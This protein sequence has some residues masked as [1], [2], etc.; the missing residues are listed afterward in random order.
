M[1]LKQIKNKIDS[2]K[3]T[4][5]VTKAMEAVSAVKMRKSQEKAL[6]GRSYAGAALSILKQL[7]KTNDPALDLYTKT[8]TEGKSLLIIVTSDKGLAGSVNSA[9]LK[10]AEQFLEGKSCDTICI[11][12]KAAEF[13]KREGKEVIREYLNVQDDVVMDDIGEISGMAMGRF[14]LGEYKEVFI[15]YQ[16]F[17]STFEQKPTLRQMLPLKE[18]DLTSMVEGIAPKTGKYAEEDVKAHTALYTFEPNA[19]MVLSAL[20][21]YLMQIMVFHALI[22]S[23]ACEHSARMVAMKNATDK[24]K[25]LTKALTIQ[26]NKAR[27]A[28]ITAE[29]SEITGGIEAMKS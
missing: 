8:R 21:A 5:K 22:E 19:E 28:Q 18:E 26:F 14:W 12:R 15:V 17:V 6:G 13:A 16:N 2:T 23:K 3:K 9:V 24:A 10:Q 25:E 11:G 20:M 7:S 29:V 27:Q 4:A 1:A